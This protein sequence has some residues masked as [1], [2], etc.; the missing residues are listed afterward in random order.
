M[1]GKEQDPGAAEAKDMEKG[2]V[3]FPWSSRRSIGRP[4][5]DIR[6]HRME[7]KPEQDQFNSG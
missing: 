4:P 2:R 6:F 1:R 7:L 5:E 3:R